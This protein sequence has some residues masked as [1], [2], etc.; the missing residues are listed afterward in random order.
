MSEGQRFDNQFSRADVN[1]DG[2][3]DEQEFRQ[4][5]GPVIRDERRLSGTLTQK[6]IQAFAVRIFSMKNVV[7]YRSLFSLNLIRQVVQQRQSLIPLVS[8]SLTLVSFKTRLN[9]RNTPEQR[10]PMKIIAMV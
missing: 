6:D 3:I 5:L 2:T 9:T 10:M 4:F 8:M 1:H 7:V